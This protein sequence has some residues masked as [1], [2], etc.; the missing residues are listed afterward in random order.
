MI[1][2]L[3]WNCRLLSVNRYF[4]T[5]TGSSEEKVIGKKIT[6]L[7]RYD[8]PET[9]E[10]LVQQVLQTSR[11]ID[12][13]ENVTI[14]G[15]S[16]CLD[17]KYKPISTE[18]SIGN[19]VLV[20]S[21]DVTK[22]KTIE[23]QLFHAEKLASLGSLSAGVAH[24]INNPIAIILGFTEMLMEKTEENSKEHGIL[25]AIERQ[26]NNCRR[27]VENLLTFARIPQKTTTETDAAEDL[28]KVI[29]VVQNT[30][31]T[32]SVDL[33]TEIP[34][35]LPRVR[36]D[37]P[38]LEQVFLNIINNAVAAMDGGGALII[39][40]HVEGNWVHIHFIDTGHG[41]PPENL[42]K[43]FEPFFTTKEVSEGT[44]LGLSVSYGIIQ[45]FGGDITVTSRTDKDGKTPGTTFTV[46]LPVADDK[47]NGVDSYNA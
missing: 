10:K 18:K 44:G 21:R 38:Q 12:S 34:K 16:Y 26:G 30:L 11:A 23:N 47:Q 19:A 28:E 7:F 31:L 15:Q 37:G 36:G 41:I 32:E 2:T 17:T 5:L 27:I 20:I 29:S 8:T 13:E 42:K 24:E 6:D 40:A 9:V 39:K 1:Y 33:K 25:K 43:I 46:K 4:S 45:K 22:H 3:D 14:D 35:H